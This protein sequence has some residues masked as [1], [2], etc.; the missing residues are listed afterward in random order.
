MVANLLEQTLDVVVIEPVF[1]LLPYSARG[2]QLQIAQDAQLLRSCRGGYLHRF[3]ELPD[4]GL[5]LCEGI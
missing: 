2:N 1:D 4:I 3:G 5:T